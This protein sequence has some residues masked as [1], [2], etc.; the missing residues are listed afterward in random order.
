M[1]GPSSL[2]GKPT[3]T[4][5]TPNVPIELNDPPWKIYSRNGILPPQY[6]G[7]SAKLSNATISEGCSIDGEI[8]NSIIFPGVTVKEGTVIRNSILMPGVTVEKGSKVEY[9]IIAADS[10]IGSRVCMGSCSGAA[11]PGRHPEITVIGQ[12]L[13]IADGTVIPA[14]TMVSESILSREGE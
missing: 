1:W 4:F 8:E 6:I 5:W 12:D 14:G 3:W 10:V 9:A 7:S 13:T 2:Y 11:E